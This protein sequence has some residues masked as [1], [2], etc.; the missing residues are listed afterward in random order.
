MRSMLKV[1]V[2]LGAMAL[3]GCASGRAFVAPEAPGGGAA[4]VYVYRATGV[5]GAGV[6]HELRVGGLPVGVMVNGGYMRVEV[7]AAEVAVT[8]PACLAS[9]STSVRVAPGSVAY[10]QL[11]LINKSVE[12]GGRHYFDYGCRLVQRSAAE[13]LAVL[14]GLRRATN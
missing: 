2:L 9:S 12:F 1:A 8:A 3:L 13:A 14:P 7:P 4:A 11:K 6:T 5:P 10:V